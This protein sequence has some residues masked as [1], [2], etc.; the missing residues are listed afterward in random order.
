MAH[1]ALVKM[2]LDEKLLMLGGQDNWHFTGVDRLGIPAIRTCDGPHGVRVHTDRPDGSCDPAT[3][4][5]CASALA[6]TFNPELL[7]EV[8]ETIAKECRHYGVQVLLAPGVNGKRS[9][10]AGRNFEYYSEDPF[11][12]GS[13]ATAFIQG[14]QHHKVGT[15]IKHFIANEQETSRLFIS[16]NVDERTLHEIYLT[17]FE[18]AI[19][20]ANPWTVMASYNRINGS[21]GCENTH[22]LMELLKT[23][24][25]YDGLVVSDWGAVNDK[26]DSVKYGLDI[27]MPGPVEL[28]LRLKAAVESGDIPMAVIDE[29]VERILRLGERVYKQ[30]ERYPSLD[31]E[32]HHTIAQKTAAETLVLLKNDGILPLKKNTTIAVIGR[33]ADDQVRYNGGGSSWLNAYRVERPL[34]AL[35]SKAKVLYAKGYDQE[36]VTKASTLEAV[37]VAKRAKTVLFFTGTT[38]SMESEGFDRANIDL[39]LAHRRLL[40]AIAKVNPNVVVILNN[41][42][43]VDLRSTEPLARAILEAWLLGSAAGQP[44]ADVLFGDINPSGKLSETFPLRL[45]HTPAYGNFPGQ[46]DHVDYTEGILVGYRHYDTRKLDVMYPF[47][48]GLSYTTFKMGPIRLSTTEL[49]VKDTLSV[50]VTLTNTGKRAGAEVI[51]LYVQDPQSTLIRP[52]KELRAFKKVFLEP[53]ESQTVSFTLNQ[54]DFAAYVTHLGRYAVESGTFNVLMGFSSRDIRR[55]ATLTVNSTDKVRPHLTLEYPYTQWI[56]YP[57]EKAQIEALVKATRPPFWWET[58]PPLSRWLLILKREF[59]WSDAEEARMKAQLL[60][61]S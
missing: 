43:A 26:V 51:Q 31:L 23:K 13:M 36:K 54:R 38:S 53:N 57:Q 11:L 19:K 49:D 3:H 15:S 50:S 8:G 18:M 29:H 48:H 24:L 14:L 37:N 32:A 34:E 21:Y 7:K 52:E 17:P 35:K 30:S 59:N 4:F 28:D 39:P 9:P 56:R 58:E 20:H 40:A 10:L 2:T 27:Q 41:G 47:G 60:E 44:I 22:T 1:P 25:G 16:S 6:A 33:F 5:P 42:A 55:K 61:E 45:E 12:S 46:T